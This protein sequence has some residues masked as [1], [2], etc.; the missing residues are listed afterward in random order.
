MPCYQNYL[1][2]YRS[3]ADFIFRNDNR[4]DEDFESL[5]R[6]IAIELEALK[7]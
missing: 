7:T 5:V 2:P 1:L 3:K 6:E 4:A